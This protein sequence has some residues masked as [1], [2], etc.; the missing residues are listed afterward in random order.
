L[1]HFTLRLIPAAAAVCLL[2][3]CGGGGG[4]APGD[5]PG[6][7]GNASTG[8]AVDG[9]LA[10]ATVL[11]DADGNGLPGDG[12]RAVGTGASGAFRFAPPCEAALAAW[13]GTNADTGLPFVGLLRSPAG[14]KVVSPLTTLIAAGLTAEQVRAA[15]GIGAGSDLLADDPAESRDGTL[16]RA[17]LLKR[18]LAA[19]QLMQKLAETYAGLAGR[20]DAA[21]VRALYAAVAEAFAEVLADGTPLIDGSTADDDVVGALVQRATAKAE[22]VFPFDAR[23]NAATLARVI[24]AALALQIETLLDA[25]VAELATVTAEVQ[26]N[27][28]IAAFVLSVA[29]QLGAAPGP[30]ADALSQQLVAQIDPYV[31]LAEN[32]IRLVDGDNRRTFT[33]AQFQSAGGVSVSWPLPEPT[34]LEV[35]IGDPGN[36]QPV[37]G[38]TVSA[39]ISITEAGGGQ[40]TILAYIDQ[41]KLERSIFGLKFTVPSTARAR[42]YGVSS[43]GRAAIVNF[44]E[45]VSGV[46]NT[47]RVGG[48]GTNS[49]AF[50]SVVEY[51]INQLSNDFSGIRSLRGTYRVSVVVSGLPVRLADGT[52]LP[53]VSVQ[54]PTSLTRT[55]EVATSRTVTG[56]GLVGTVTLTD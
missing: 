28:R 17:G 1:T 3:S 30:F 46:T 37:A 29:D 45:G 6:P 19:Q 20:T 9:Y 10:G 48:T 27:G 50:G 5:Y 12:E 26:G 18:N 47:L 4:T 36:Y 15:F 53:A 41:V 21:D 11:C 43:D 56:R 40:G 33:A 14:A 13:G 7:D 22:A 52:P 54:V 49:I 2:A 23:I 31:T 34:A 55:G 35:T 8:V 25:P 24:R 42:A 38:Q 32:A 51:T 16:L 39:A 44:S